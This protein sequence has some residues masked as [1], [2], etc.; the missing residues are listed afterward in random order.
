MRYLN[1]RDEFLKN[2]NNI[3]KIKESYVPKSKKEQLITENDNA[4]PFVNNVG[5]GDSLIGRAIHAVMRKARIGVN[6]VRIKAVEQRLRDAMDELLLNTSVAELDEDDKKLY[7]RALITTYLLALEEGVENGDP[8]LEL[9][10]LTESAIL[11]VE[12]NK[13]LED[14]NE[15]IRQLN[16]WKKYLEQFKEEEI[17][18]EEDDVTEEKRTATETYLENF[19]YLF[20]MLLTYQGI[21]LELA[22]AGGAVAA[23]PSVVSATPS[24][25]NNLEVGKEY[26][27]KN[28]KGVELPVKIIS[29]DK[30]QTI[31]P[32]GE[33]LTKDDIIGTDVIKKDL[34]L[35]AFK[36]KAGLY[37]KPM[38]VKKS[39]LKPLPGGE[40]VIAKATPVVQNSSKLVR[41]N[42]FLRINENNAAGATPS[43]TGTQ[44]VDGNKSVI[45]KPIGKVI[46]AIWKFITGSKDERKLDE[47]TK[48]LWEAI[49]PLYLA[50]ISEPN[51]LI[52]DGEF[53][54]FLNSD[55]RTTD[56]GYEKY[57]ASIDK[58]YANIRSIN[59]INEDVHTIL[60]KS[61]EIGKHIAGIYTVTK[62][63]TDG[64]FMKYVDE[65]NK[66]EVKGE[67]WDVFTDD[68]KGFNESMKDVLEVKSKWNEGDSA[69]WKSKDTGKPI[70]KEILRIDGRD[71][72]FKDKSGKEFTK[73]M[74]DVEKVLEESINLLRYGSFLR[75][76]ENKN[77][78]RQSS[79]GSGS[80]QQPT[81][82]TPPPVT[83]PPA[84]VTDPTAN[85]D[86]E[87]EDTDSTDDTTD[88]TNTGD[89]DGEVSGWKNPN[90]VTKI[91]DWWGKK[92][93]LK[94]WVLEKTEVEKV[95]I[96]LDKKLAA[97]KD[98][99]VIDGMDP[100]LEIVKVFNR[101]YKLH[102][103][104]VIPSGRTAG[105]VPNSVFMEYHCFGNGSPAT[106]GESGG[107]YRNN[108]I[109]NQWED[110]VNDVKK[111]TR[112]QCI[113]N[114][115]TR[116]KVGN[117]YIEKAGSNLRKFMDD[118]LD[119]D[120]L[121]KS[122]TGTDSQGAQSKFLDK[123]FGYKAETD[124]KDTYYNSDDRDEVT[125]VANSMP[126]VE[127]K[128]VDGA[129]TGIKIEK[130]EDLKYTFFS[131]LVEIGGR[132]QR[133]YLQI[134]DV[135]DNL[136]F[137]N[138][139]KTAFYMK[140]TLKSSNVNITIKLDASM[141]ES[142]HKNEKMDFPIMATTA[143]VT[144]IY[145]KDGRLLTG[146]IRIEGVT[147][148]DDDGK[149]DNKKG[150]IQQV[151]S[152]GTVKSA[153]HIVDL[154]KGSTTA[155]YKRVKAN[156][157]ATDKTIND[158]GGFKNISTISE[159]RQAK[160]TRR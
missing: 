121:Y 146:G 11:A 143:K 54:K 58:V 106:A 78:F 69:T 137:I 160:I 67:T 8:M 70:T 7:A 34:A 91:Q 14:K 52:R 95:R 149:V 115:G 104:Q 138:Y 159:V 126:A 109:F 13:D 75:I 51:I 86:D 135:K 9:M 72:V 147:R 158:Y 101:A 61:D 33:F 96:N 120:E 111:D 20:D 117:E 93:D 85:D 39:N 142:A 127:L 81:P 112:Y 64:N 22:K 18:E 140:E 114:V 16:E 68:I 154:S 66:L 110:C 36:D 145:A 23:T 3:V 38:T 82:V 134:Q 77:K 122:G 97:K 24:V 88:G 155:D 62:E 41:Y 79:K 139:S 151:K 26:L 44:P 73:S 71:L 59:G 141:K 76:D 90:S 37:K 28:A 56:D 100:I 125:A 156:Q 42:D 153:Q 27:H 35:V 94:R 108:A 83:P 65:I 57:K 132:T 80:K 92:M 4:G 1:K 133:Y 136:L 128:F 46:G 116:L 123:Y 48:K 6:L 74:D 84:D 2:Y 102:T 12:Q 129:S 124:G 105:K 10:N 89:E 32:D 29:L 118:M 152:E 157:T 148:L 15:L 45:G 113:F 98:S 17:Q 99:V 5:W 150:K 119:G 21:T 31:G 40:N 43:N 107:P 53:H 103:T 49:Q 63:K 131:L 50:F 19:K 55:D 130:N 47:D 30:T 60:E 144:D 87:D 25:A